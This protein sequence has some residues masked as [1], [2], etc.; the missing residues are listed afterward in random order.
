[1]PWLIDWLL[2]WW[3]VVMTVQQCYIM[4]QKNWSWLLWIWAVW[5][6]N[7]KNPQNFI[8]LFHLQLRIS[9]LCTM[10]ELMHTTSNQKFY[11]SYSLFQN[12]NLCTSPRTVSYG[13]NVSPSLSCLHLQSCSLKLW[14]RLGS[15]CRFNDVFT[16][17]IL[18][19]RGS[20]F[21]FLFPLNIC[22]NV[23]AGS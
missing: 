22:L 18:M 20:S 17:H 13:N 2:Y 21:L 5:I 11:S 19:Y 6:V 4:K 12:S 7:R 1:M 9:H 16:W 23:Q 14:P 3:K 10:M 15:N 8:S